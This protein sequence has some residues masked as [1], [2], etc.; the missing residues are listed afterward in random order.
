M[1]LNNVINDF[2]FKTL[3]LRDPTPQESPDWGINGIKIEALKGTEKKINQR[4]ISKTDK[5][6][7]SKRMEIKSK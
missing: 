2:K 4:P 5:S 7:S 6:T 3:I 1:S